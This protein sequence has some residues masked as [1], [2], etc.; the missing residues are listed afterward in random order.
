MKTRLFMLLLAVGLLAAAVFTGLS[1]PASAQT[2]TVPVQL[3][4]GEVV[5]V[6]VDVPPGGTVE[7]VQLPGT[8]VEPQPAPAPTTPAPAP[9]PK[10]EA[11]TPAPAPKPGPPTVDGGAPH[12]L[13]NC[14]VKL[15]REMEMVR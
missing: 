2:Q 8:P 14:G 1:I 4:N 7:D 10:P 11:T 13:T 3:P 6:Q 9:Q 12:E 5:D 15:E